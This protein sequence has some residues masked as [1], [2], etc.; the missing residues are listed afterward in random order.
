MNRFSGKV[1][2][3]TGS[4]FGIGRGIAA[5]FAEEDASVAI[6]DNDS[7]KAQETAK[8]IPASNGNALAVN[9]NVSNS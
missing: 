3:V 2:V 6:L 7:A 8:M 5:R 4:G 1:V 9:V